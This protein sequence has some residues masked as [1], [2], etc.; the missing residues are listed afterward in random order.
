MNEYVF[1]CNGKADIV[2]SDSLNI[3]DAARSEI[4]RY[5]IGDVFTVSDNKGRCMTYRKIDNGIELIAVHGM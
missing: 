5:S 3:S 2:Q 4:S 1:A